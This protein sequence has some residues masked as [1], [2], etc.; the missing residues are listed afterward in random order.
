VLDRETIEGDSLDGSVTE[1]YQ[2][3]KLLARGLVADNKDNIAILIK[4]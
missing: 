3:L 2:S 4:V 1:T